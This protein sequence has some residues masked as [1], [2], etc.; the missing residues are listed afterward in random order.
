MR[1]IRCLAAQRVLSFTC[2]ALGLL[3]LRGSAAGRQSAPLSLA[4]IIEGIFG[5]AGSEADVNADGAVSA[6]DVVAA[7]RAAVQPVPTATPAHSWTPSPTPTPAASPS[8]SPSSP[9]SRTPT[10]SSPSPT[11]TATPYLCPG[12]GADLVI[13]IENRTGLERVVAV[14]RGER[15]ES[16]CVGGS[17]A[18]TYSAEV[19]CRGEGA[20]SC[21][22]L[23]GLRPGLWRHSIEVL[24][25]PTGQVQHRRS[26]LLARTAPN[27]TAFRVFP[28][29]LR[30]ATTAD[31]GAGSLRGAIETANALAR[32]PTPTAPPP[33][34]SATPTEAPG[35]VFSPTPTASPGVSAPAAAASDNTWRA[36]SAVAAGPILIQFD[37]AAFPDGV[38]TAIQLAAQ[39]PNLQASDV[40]IDG[41]DGTG[42]P[43][44]RIVDAAGLPIPALAISGARNHVLGL[45]LRN[46][47]GNDRDGLNISG[48]VADANVIEQ[49]AVE[50]VATAD[51]I[52]VDLEAGKDFQES[53]NVIRDC[54]VSG[55]A[56]KGVKVT[57][58]AYAVV[59]NCWVHDNANGGIQATLGGHVRAWHNVIEDNRGA[60]AQ[61][62]L[63]VNALDEGDLGSGLSELE[64]WGNISRRNGA[65]GV[66]VRA[67]SRARISDCYF[68]ANAAAGVRV[69]NDVGPP[70]EARIEGSSA[71]CNEIDGAVV[72]DQ[73][74]ADFGG[75]W[76]ES[77]GN[78][79]FAQNNRPGGVNFRNATGQPVRA[80]G[81]QWEHCGR[82][83][84]CD[85]A[86]IARLDVSD[87]GTLT[88][89][90]PAQAHRALPTPVIRAVY[91]SK[92][93]AGERLRIFG[94]G[95]NAI[96]GHWDQRSTEN[97]CADV[98]SRNRCVPLRGNCVQIGGVSAP[99]EAVTPTLLVVRWPFTCVEPVPL[100]VRVD[101]GA[102]GNIS[103]PFWVC[104]N[105]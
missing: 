19:E 32:A 42:A 104:T 98:E 28:V 38:P 53:A 34:P 31:S 26:L 3:G 52:G 9:P 65:N 95:F 18:D 70:A 69:H 15:I 37:S 48:P 13:D 76:L 96:D 80:I 64:A 68:A 73:S 77:P 92:G 97:S 11:P 60:T 82:G 20:V 45:R 5:A 83:S 21:A 91:P 100:V 35:E 88:Q 61:N 14:L 33:E 36:A 102:T 47:G 101:Q 93:R 2:V 66:S 43:G 17:G 8:P 79:A 55:A 58:G 10:P 72:A 89:F 99:V 49:V 41:I 71:V 7:L 24:E 50:G 81:N 29:V 51:G 84:V 39:L 27:R 4:P 12:E 54:E 75:G 74:A 16:S 1:R 67:F 57:R 46:V 86:E 44:N 6:A 23:S 94:S 63:A 105:D 103:E 30:V 22:A 87:K 59:V 78:N 62:G 25:P 56:D 90:V 85:E 40:T